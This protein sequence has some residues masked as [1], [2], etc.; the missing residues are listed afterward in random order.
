M[1]DGRSAVALIPLAAAIM[2]RA[3]IPLAAAVMSRTQM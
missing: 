3:L 2:S 1:R